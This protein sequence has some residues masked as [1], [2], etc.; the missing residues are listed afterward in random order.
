[1]DCHSGISL[2]H[3][4]ISEEIWESS[5]LGILGFS[6]GQLNAS[7]NENNTA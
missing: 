3:L 7:V 2:D 1:M 4:G 6:Y 5:L